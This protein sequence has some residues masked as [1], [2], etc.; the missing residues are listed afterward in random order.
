MQTAARKIADK[1]NSTYWWN[2]ELNTAHPGNNPAVTHMT[3]YSK[4]QGHDEAR[5]KEYLLYAKII[6]LVEHGYTARSKK[7]SIHWK[8]GALIN[9]ISDPVLLELYP[10]D[11]FIPI[12]LL[13][14]KQYQDLQIFVD[15]VYTC[16]RD[17]KPVKFLLPK[18][19]A[20]F[21]KD[22]YFD[23]TKLHFHNN[24]QLQKYCTRLINNGHPF[25]QVHNFYLKYTEVKPFKR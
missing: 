7:I 12:E 9:K 13:K 5:D 16:I 17:N 21:S 18:R 1:S 14:K 8:R 6:M 4:F 22:D 19:K 24:E 15:K 25:D 23:I 11:F 10:R 3:G 20:Q 2:M